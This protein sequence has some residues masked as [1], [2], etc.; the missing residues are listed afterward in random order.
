LISAG[1][2][3]GWTRGETRLECDLAL[4]RRAHPVLKQ[5]IA[6]VGVQNYLQ[7]QMKSPS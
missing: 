7:S 5:A 4:E 3:T 1:T 6:D 2:S